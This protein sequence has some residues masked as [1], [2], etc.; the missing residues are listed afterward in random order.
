MSAKKGLVVGTDRSKSA[1][2]CARK[3]HPS[4]RTTRNPRGLVTIEGVL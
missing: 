2:A 4:G 3:R 1:V